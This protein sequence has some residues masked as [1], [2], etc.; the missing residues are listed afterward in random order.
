VTARQRWRPAFVLPHLTTF[1]CESAQ[2]SLITNMG[3]PRHPDLLAQ[4]MPPS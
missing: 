4:R 2:A 3:E 1:F